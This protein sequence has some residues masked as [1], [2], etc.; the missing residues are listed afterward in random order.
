V[1]GLAR[2]LYLMSG[3]GLELDSLCADSDIGWGSDILMYRDEKFS[4]WKDYK[5]N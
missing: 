3:R 4:I 5:D 2:W 1:L